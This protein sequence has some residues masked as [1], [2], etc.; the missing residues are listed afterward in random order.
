MKAQFRTDEILDHARQRFG[1]VEQDRRWS[2]A[3]CAG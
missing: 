3:G 1:L 2:S